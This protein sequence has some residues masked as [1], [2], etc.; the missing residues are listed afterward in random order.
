MSRQS[1]NVLLSKGH[2][3]AAILCHVEFRTVKTG[4]TFQFD[5]RQ[6]H[7]RRAPG[8]EQNA[9]PSGARYR[10]APSTTGC[11]MV[12]VVFVVGSSRHFLPRL[13]LRDWCFTSRPQRAFFEASRNLSSDVG[14]EK[15]SLDWS[16]CGRACRFQ[17][18]IWPNASR[19]PASFPQQHRLPYGRETCTH[20]SGMSLAGLEIALTFLSSQAIPQCSSSYP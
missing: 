11:Y 6:L 7:G 15:P 9:K 3:L 19:E 18:P 17:R 13:F 14:S 8:Q 1:S 4:Y 2:D 16:D 12:R 20:C 5:G 10:E